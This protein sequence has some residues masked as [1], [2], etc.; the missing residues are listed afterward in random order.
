[1]D[2]VKVTYPVKLVVEAAGV[3]DG[4]PGGDSPPEGRLV[5][6]AVRAEGSLASCSRLKVN[7]KILMSYDSITVAA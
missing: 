3:A 4:F 5:G 1:M 7:G 2:D 6:A